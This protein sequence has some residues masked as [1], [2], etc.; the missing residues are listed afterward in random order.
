[1]TPRALHLFCLAALLSCAWGSSLVTIQ[2]E[3]KTEE[4]FYIDAR[5]N[6][7]INILFQVIRGGKLDIRLR[8]GILILSFFGN[9][10]S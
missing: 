2:V 1:M 6:E 9:F 7:A 8:V 10:A 5:A 4:C 3:P